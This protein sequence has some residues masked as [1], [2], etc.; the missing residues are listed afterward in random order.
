[1][2]TKFIEVSEESERKRQALEAEYRERERKHEE[3][4]LT[5]MIGIMRQVSSPP[6]QGFHTY[7]LHSTQSST[8][9]SMPSHSFDFPHLLVLTR[10]MAALKSRH[11]LVLMVVNNKT[12]SVSRRT[13]YHFIITRHRRCLCLGGMLCIHACLT[14]YAELKHTSSNESLLLLVEHYASG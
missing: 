5:M 12:L 9:S 11:L 2:L 6:P 4:M 13:S 1:M 8:Y 7:P 10:L 3:R 14:K